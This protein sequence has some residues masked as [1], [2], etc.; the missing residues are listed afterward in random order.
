MVRV[1]KFEFYILLNGRCK[2]I[3]D[4]YNSDKVVNNVDIL[5]QSLAD[6]ALTYIIF[7]APIYRAHLA[8]VFAIAQFS[9]IYLH[10]FD[11]VCCVSES[12]LNSDKFLKL[13]LLFSRP[14]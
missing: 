4:V 9:C 10:C 7:R 11:A 5:A 1:V 8:V 6:F 2:Q 12:P 3:G 13:S 14:A